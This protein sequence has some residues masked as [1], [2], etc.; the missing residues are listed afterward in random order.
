MNDRKREEP[1]E[2]EKH[3]LGE[4]PDDSIVAELARKI[5]A[6]QTRMASVGKVTPREP[7]FM[8]DLLRKGLVF[9]SINPTS[10][11]V[12][13]SFYLQPL[14]QEGS[15][16]RLGGMAA[17]SGNLILAIG[18]ELESSRNKTIILYTSEKIG[19]AAFAR[20]GFSRLTAEEF[21]TQHP[22]WYNAYAESS[23]TH[24]AGED[25][26]YYIRVGN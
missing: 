10:G 12:V 5:V 13:S 20:N 3:G 24:Q 8:E 14:D 7:A 2:F 9:Y 26:V 16:Y 19:R 1:A 15:A 23:E 22:E 21:Q 11:E 18:R 25:Q 4:I 17:S 6:L